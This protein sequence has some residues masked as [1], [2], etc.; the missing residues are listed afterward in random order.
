MCGRARKCVANSTKFELGGLRC[1]TVQTYTLLRVLL[2]Y[3]VCIKVYCMFLLACPLARLFAC[4]LA[5]LFACSLLVRSLACLPARAILHNNEWARPNVKFEN[6][7]ICSIGYGDVRNVLC[8]NNFT[9][10][11]FIS[12]WGLMGNCQNSL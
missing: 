5:R 11:I 2:D 3:H 10:L 9:S 6:V 12:G 8:N 4:S 7:S 1:L